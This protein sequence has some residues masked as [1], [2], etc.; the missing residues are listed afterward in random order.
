MHVALTLGYKYMWV[1]SFFIYFFLNTLRWN[2]KYFFLYCFFLA[3][4]K[5]RKIVKRK[6]ELIND[7]RYQ[8]HVPLNLN[9][10]IGV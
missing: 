1:I 5:R 2:G 3:F 7:E 10:L 4:E 6:I 8:F 9:K